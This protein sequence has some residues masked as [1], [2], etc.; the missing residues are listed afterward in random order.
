MNPL[1]ARASELPPA[2]A[3]KHPWTEHIVLARPMAQVAD[4]QTA[5]LRRESTVL[6]AYAANLGATDMNLHLGQ[7]VTA[8]VVRST[9]PDDRQKIAE[10]HVDAAARLLVLN[11]IPAAA[12]IMSIELPNEGRS[13]AGRTRFGI[14]PPPTLAAMAT[15][16]CAI[17]EPVILQS[18][19]GDE[20]LPNEPDSALGRM[21]GTTRLH[22]GL[23]TIGVYW[24]TYGFAPGDSVEIAIR[25]QRYTAQSALEKVG[26]ALNMRGDKNAPV[27]L[28]WT[29]P[30]P[31]HASHVTAG[32][33]P[34]V[35]RS[36]V[37]NI[38]SLPKGDYWLDIGV[39]KNRQE[40]VVGRRS[41]V[42]Q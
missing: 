34:I 28:A 12:A 9:G 15:G 21:S 2:I 17:S 23:K 13:V 11:T 41:F 5:L 36:I 3:E 26:I 35:S 18:P 10:Q 27:S 29:E 14:A 24:E 39:R 4:D 42:V 32:S 22:A 38:A 30:Q 7:T 40:P 16:E 1:R 19:P 33:V 8:I 25:V 6:F 20:P 31:G 37:L